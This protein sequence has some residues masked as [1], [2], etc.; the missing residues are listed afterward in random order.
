[1]RPAHAA[2]QFCSEQ[3]ELELQ[4]SA[5]YWAAGIQED[6]IFLSVKTASFGKNHPNPHERPQR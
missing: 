1:M 6:I 2:A 5:L 3:A 4:P